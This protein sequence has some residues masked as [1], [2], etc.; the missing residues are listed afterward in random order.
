MEE[1]IRI[2]SS[3][4]DEI[5]EKIVELEDFIELNKENEN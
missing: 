1:N 5:I 4:S 3:I 2:E